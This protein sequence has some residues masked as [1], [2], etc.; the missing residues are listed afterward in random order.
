MSITIADVLLLW[1]VMWTDR[2]NK[3]YSRLETNFM[4]GYGPHCWLLS[5]GFVVHIS[6]RRRGSIIR[7]LGIDTVSCVLRVEL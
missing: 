5:R 7:K 2:W 4:G 6:V 1:T 3:C